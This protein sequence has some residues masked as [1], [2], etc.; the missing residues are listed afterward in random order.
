MTH[1]K[2]DAGFTLIELLVSLTLLALLLALM[3]STLRLSKRAWE[4]A[5]RTTEATAMAT[6]SFAVHNVAYALPVFVRDQSGLQTLA[7]VG[8]RERLSFIANLANGPRGGGL[9]TIA[10]APSPGASGKSAY[11]VSMSA[12]R[13]HRSSVAATSDIRTLNGTYTAISFRYFGRQKPG[14]N[15]GWTDNWPRSSSLPDLVE[16]S[17]TGPENGK[18]ETKTTKIELRLRR[19]Y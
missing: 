2:R 7:F 4:T 18:S 9:Y 15:P 1:A 10:I 12:F 19:A 17:A 13:D 3:P 16:V 6:L 14:G 11:A 8:A 5:N